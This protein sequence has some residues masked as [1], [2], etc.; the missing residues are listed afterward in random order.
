MSMR[1]ICLSCCPCN[2]QLFLSHG[3]SCKN[4][5]SPTYKRGREFF[6]SLRA[7]LFENDFNPEE[8]LRLNV[9][10]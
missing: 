10:S 3:F 6:A 1:T 7:L 4:I 9:A 8:K 2:E 5:L